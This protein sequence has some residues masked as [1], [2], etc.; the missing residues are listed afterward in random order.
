M[1]VVEAE[2]RQPV[3]SSLRRTISVTGHCM[4]WSTRQ[5]SRHYVVELRR[6]GSR[7]ATGIGS[8]VHLLQ[9]RMFYGLEQ[10]VLSSI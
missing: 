6:M 1:E 3:S 10:R 5:R 4:G 2:D 8:S 9:D 7:L